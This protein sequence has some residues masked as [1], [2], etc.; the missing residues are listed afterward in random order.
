MRGVGKHF[1]LAVACVVAL[2]GCSKD[3]SD[4]TPDMGN[5]GAGVV[6]NDGGKAE[7]GAG[8]AAGAGGAGGSDAPVMCVNNTVVCK[9]GPI[10]M[11]KGCCTDDQSLAS[12]VSRTKDVCG[13]KF[14]D[15]VPC[16]ELNAP[17]EMDD[18]CPQMLDQGWGAH[19]GCCHP[20]FHVCGIINAETGCT[21][22]RPTAKK[23]DGEMIGGMG[24]GDW[25]C[26]P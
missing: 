22:Y 26:T 16:F 1:A 7:G 20:D 23:P 6:N 12:Y 9:D 8:A 10:Q 5:G 25:T 19:P 21:L 15:R 14:P 11:G 3:D 13:L 18:E 2:L 17:G 24:S 4:D